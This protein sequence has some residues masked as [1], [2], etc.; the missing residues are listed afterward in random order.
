MPP[1]DVDDSPPP[2]GAMADAQRKRTFAL[3]ADAAAMPPPDALSMRARIEYK[4]RSEYKLVRHMV[5]ASSAAQPAPAKASSG[6]DAPFAVQKEKGAHAAAVPEA[7]AATG[8]D[9]GA[10]A[11]A[12]VPTLPQHEVQRRLNAQSQYP[13]PTWHAPW[14]LYRVV[15]GHMGWVRSIAFDPAN[16]WFCTGA[17][18]RTIKLWDLASGTLKLTLTGHTEQVTGLAVSPRSPYLFSAGIDKSVKCWDL[19][20]NKVIR[21]YHGHL[22]GVYSLAL[23]PSLEILFTGGRDSCTRVWDIRTRAQVHVLSGHSNTVVS[24][25]TQ[26]VDPQIISGSQDSQIKLWDLAAGKTM[27]TLT[28]HKKGVRAL[29]MHPREFCFSACS[30]DAV[31]KYKLPHGEF[32]MNMGLTA[33]GSMP[34]VCGTAVGSAGSPAGIANFS[35]LNDEDVMVTGNEEGILCFFDWRSGHRF[36]DIKSPLQPGSLESESAIYCGK[37]DGTGTRLIV[38]SADKTL[39]FYKEDPTATPSTHPL[40]YRPPRDR[41]RRY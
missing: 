24:L 10:L 2:L 23:H 28:Y 11:L 34:L 20:Y 7:T 26:K 9:M 15:S 12:N 1:A 3:F 37:F 30:A 40:E 35:A 22:S 32:L 39:R 21:S 31:K 14:T 13:R 36:Q 19:E 38:G 33:N 41:T 4:L 25:A 8:A 6:A 18:D 27:S 17:A 16:E 29:Q 5:P